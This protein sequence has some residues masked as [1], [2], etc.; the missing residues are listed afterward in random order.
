MTFRS[1]YFA[2]LVLFLS[3]SCRANDVCDV[4][5]CKGKY[6]FIDLCLY[7]SPGKSIPEKIRMGTGAVYDVCPLFSEKKKFS[8]T[9][10]I[11]KILTDLGKSCKRFQSMTIYGHGSPGIIHNSAEDDKENINSRTISNFSEFGCLTKAGAAIAL[12]GCNVGRGCS[13]D[14]FMYQ[15]AEALLPN[16][17]SVKAPTYYTTSF[18]FIGY[19]SLNGMSRRLTYSPKSTAKDTWSYSGIPMAADSSLTENCAK[20]IGDRLGTYQ[21][22]KQKADAMSCDPHYEMVPGEL[23]ELAELQKQFQGGK[24]PSMDVLNFR[25]HVADMNEDRQTSIPELFESIDI[26]TAALARCRPP[27]SNGGQSSHGTSTK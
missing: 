13:G 3:I 12:V 8:T 2:V 5:S 18:P 4:P 7:E 14:Y 27:E 15:I 17:G 24:I 16:G 25:F 11:K 9:S 6:N 1:S 10:D 23:E 22:L 26:V 20:E 19:L 21:E